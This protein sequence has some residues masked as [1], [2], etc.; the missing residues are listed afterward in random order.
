MWVR[1]VAVC[2]GFMYRVFENDVDH[3]VLRPGTCFLYGIGWRAETNAFVS[4][5]DDA[6]L[7]R[8][9]FIRACE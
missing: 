9:G 7:W 8:R 2:G 4:A 5:D 6:I 3:E 1:R